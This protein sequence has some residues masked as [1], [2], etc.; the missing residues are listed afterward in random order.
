MDQLRR[1]RLL[2]GDASTAALKNWLQRRRGGRKSCPTTFVPACRFGGW[3][4]RRWRRAPAE[5]F[6]HRQPGGMD[7][8]RK[9]NA[10]LSLKQNRIEMFHLSID[11]AGGSAIPG[12]NQCSFP[13]EPAGYVLVGGRSSRMGRDKALLPFRGGALAESRLAP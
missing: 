11:E 4:A 13:C 2:D 5:G 10:Q 12:C 8:R 7:G 6:R 1:Q 3:P 9:S